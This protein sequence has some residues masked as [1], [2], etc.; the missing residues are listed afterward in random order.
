MRK[1]NLLF[2]LVAIETSTGHILPDETITCIYKTACLETDSKCPRDTRKDTPPG[3][4]QN[5]NHLAGGGV[6]VG[7]RTVLQPGGPCQCYPLLLL[8]ASYLYMV[9]LGPGDI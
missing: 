5:K 3:N 2:Q 4:N 6:G 7:E 8:T 9:C 1:H